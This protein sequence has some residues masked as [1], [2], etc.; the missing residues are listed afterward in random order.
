MVTRFIVSA[1]MVTLVQDVRAVL[2]DSLGSQRK[3]GNSANLVSAQE[4]LILACLDH[5]TL[6]MANACYALIIPLGL[7]V[8][9][10]LLGSMETRSISRTVR[11]AYA[12]K[13]G[14]NTVIPTLVHAI[15]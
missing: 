11:P 12:I 8:I 7:R 6:S 5:V 3:K 14:Q 15:A 2:Q 4:T 1:S 13:W 10:V 9:F